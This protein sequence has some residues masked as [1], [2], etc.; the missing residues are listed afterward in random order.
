MEQCAFHSWQANSK[1]LRVKILYDSAELGQLFSL[2]IILFS[3][4]P[5]HV[6]LYLIQARFTTLDFENLKVYVD[7]ID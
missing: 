5:W 2:R 7:I 4:A 3:Q 1:D 6:S